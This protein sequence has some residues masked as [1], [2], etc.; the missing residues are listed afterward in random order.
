MRTHVPRTMHG[1]NQGDVGSHK[2]GMKV[3]IFVDFIR[4]EGRGW[5]G[6]SSELCNH[7]DLSSLMYNDKRVSLLFVSIKPRGI[8]CL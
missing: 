5:A 2:V 6:G 7:L 4:V 8:S 1:L 3:V